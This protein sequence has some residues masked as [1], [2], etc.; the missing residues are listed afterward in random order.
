MEAKKSISQNTGNYSFKTSFSFL[1]KTYKETFKLL[2][3]QHCMDTKKTPQT[4]RNNLLGEYGLL[5]SMLLRTVWMHVWSYPYDCTN[6][7]GLVRMTVWTFVCCTE[8]CGSLYGTTCCLE[9]PLSW[10]P[11]LSPSLY[12]STCSTVLCL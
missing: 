9:M 6:L 8:L 11:A 3:K 12:R 7:Y 1:Q 5:Y 2:K 4:E 10:L